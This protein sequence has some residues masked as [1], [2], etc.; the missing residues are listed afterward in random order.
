MGANGVPM[1]SGPKAASGSGA[2]AGAGGGGGGGSGGGDGGGGGGLGGAAPNAK[3]K[4]SGGKPDGAV[5][6]ADGTAKG[7]AGGGVNAST[8]AVQGGM[9]KLQK[10]G[11]LEIPTMVTSTNNGQTIVAFTAKMDID[12]D[13]AGSAWKSDRTGQQGTALQYR[14][15]TSLNPTTLPYIVVPLDFGNTH[16][17]VKLGDYVEVTYSPANGK[18]Q[19]YYAIVG[20]KGPAGVL[21]EGSIRLARALGINPDPNTGGTKRKEV[22]YRILAGSADAET[23]RDA[24]AIQTQAKRKFGAAFPPVQ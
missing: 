11:P 5:A 18:P 20:D 2:S 3:P 19:T 23:A 8:D 22:T 17:N 24:A 10:E 7:G 15:G 14:D 6:S 21:G 9:F 4:E 12:A 16:P 13:G 1:A